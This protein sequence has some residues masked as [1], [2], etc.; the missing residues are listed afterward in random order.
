M[1]AVSLNDCT[2]SQ[3]SLSGFESCESGSEFSD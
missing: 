2:D 3:A 1:K